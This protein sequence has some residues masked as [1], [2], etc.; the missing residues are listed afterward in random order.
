MSTVKWIAFVKRKPGISVEA[1][2]RR[3]GYVLGVPT[4]STSGSDSTKSPGLRGHVR[5][6]VLVSGYRGKSEPFCDGMV[7]LWF[8]DHEALEAARA[9]GT[10]AAAQADDLCD[11]AATIT[12]VTAEHLIKDGPK[13]PAGVKNVEL[14]TRRRDLPVEEFHRYWLEH[15]GPLAATIPPILRYVQ[16]HSIE[17]PRT[18][19]YDGIA[20][21]WFE[22][23]NAMRRS[24]Q[25]EA[26][27]LT[28]EDED[29]FVSGP[30]SFVITREQVIR[31]PPLLHPPRG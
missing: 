22:D 12:L 31:D 13:P 17:D 20:S 29:N 1:F 14:V 5:S 3:P 23:T 10:L 21:T 11:P 26:Y 9:N 27:R 4:Q 7:E 24:A 25:S 8:A 28:R 30:L 15:H 19:L 2:Q 16:S 6:T 18:R